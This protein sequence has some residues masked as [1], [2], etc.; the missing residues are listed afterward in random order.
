MHQIIV[1]CY[2]VALTIEF[3]PDELDVDKF[4]L[5][6]AHEKIP[7]YQS[8]ELAT[9]AADLPW[10]YEGGSVLDTFVKYLLS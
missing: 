10:N 7:T 9:M 3:S 6:L 1:S 2:D 4:A 5:L 8:F